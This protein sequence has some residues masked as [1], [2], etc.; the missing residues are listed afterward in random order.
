MAGPGAFSDIMPLPLSS[1]FE[2]IDKKKPEVKIIEEE[3]E[4][5][6]KARDEIKE[7]PLTDDKPDK[8]FEEIFDVDEVEPA[9]EDKKKKP[10]PA[11][12]TDQKK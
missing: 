9:T 7:E 1:G 2:S 4:K 12:E 8:E 11:K 3:E 10:T 6:E 5:K